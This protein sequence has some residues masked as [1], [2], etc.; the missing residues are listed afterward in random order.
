MMNNFWQMNYIV[1]FHCINLSEQQ[2]KI[3]LTS[4]TKQNVQFLKI[5]VELN[6]MG[7]VINK[8]Y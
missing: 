2:C 6:V 4:W 5:L 1:T 7:K 3:K 8:E